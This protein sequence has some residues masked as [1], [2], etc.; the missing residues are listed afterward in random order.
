[1]I[2]MMRISLRIPGPNDVWRDTFLS[3]VMD[4]ILSSVMVWGDGG[5]GCRRQ[6]MLR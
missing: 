5:E 2:E 4:R 1:M 6:T 3:S